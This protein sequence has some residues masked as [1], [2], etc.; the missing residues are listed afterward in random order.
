M[1]IR[2]VKHIRTVSTNSVHDFQ[3]RVNELLQD[4]YV[5]LQIGSEIEHD[6]GRVVTPTIAVL[7]SDK[8]APL[9]PQ[10]FYRQLQNA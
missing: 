8:P 5:L 4:G 7:G 3:A 2:D 1:D 6:K 9:P 10:V